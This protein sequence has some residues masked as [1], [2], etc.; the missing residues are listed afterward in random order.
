MSS[1]LETAYLKKINE[2]GI[3]N[4]INLNKI[5][6]KL[7]DRFGNIIPANLEIND[8]KIDKKFMVS[9]DRYSFHKGSNEFM[10]DLSESIDFS[11]FKEYNPRIIHDLCDIIIFFIY[12]FFLNN[13]EINTSINGKISE[14][15]SEKGNSGDS[16]TNYLNNIETDYD[17]ISNRI[18]YM[19]IVYVLNKEDMIDDITKMFESITYYSLNN[20]EENIFTIKYKCFLGDKSCKNH[21]HDDFILKEING[22]MV[23]NRL[24]TKGMDDL[25][26][27]CKCTEKLTDVQK[28]INDKMCSECR[29]RMYT[30]KF[31]FVFFKRNG[32]IY[33]NDLARRSK[34]IDCDTEKI[35]GISTELQ[36][37]KVYTIN[38]GTS[39]IVFE[40]LN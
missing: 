31:P 24:H 40:L 9:L 30:S 38:Y 3:N 35:L 6:E 15:E 23:F 26:K 20:N 27:N 36:F 17:R 19:I 34:F 8:L 11:S 14:K 12:L 18:L 33:L 10:K 21:L 32:K 13:K 39:T 16:Y 28:V 4:I 7:K 25:I 22:C 29:I 5:F 1:I 2:E 37:N